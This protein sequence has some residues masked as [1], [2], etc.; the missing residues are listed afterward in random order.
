MKRIGI[1]FIS[2]RRAI[3]RPAPYA[4]R[5]GAM[6]PTIAAIRLRRIHRRK[7]SSANLIQVF[8]HPLRPNILRY[9]FNL[10]GG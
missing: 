6:P 3:R 9:M 10:L 7:L 5:Y 1:A 2:S 4:A 8:F